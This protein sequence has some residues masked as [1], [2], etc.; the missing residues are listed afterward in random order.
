[1]YSAGQSETNVV[2]SN[3]IDES[4]VE[5]SDED[6]GLVPVVIVVLVFGGVFV[7]GLSKIREQRRSGRTSK[8]PRIG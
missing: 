2:P 1:M 8:F 5:E 7:F 3:G 4:P 6:S